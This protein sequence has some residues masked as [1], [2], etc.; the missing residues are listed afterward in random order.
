MTDAPDPDRILP[1]AALAAMPF[2]IWVW[3]PERRLVFANPAV[4]RY[5]GVD[6]AELPCG[7]PFRDAVRLLAYRGAFGPGDPEA[8]VAQHLMLD[9]SRPLRR[10][11]RRADGTCHE[12]HNIPL[13]GGGFC[14]VVIEITGYIAATEEATALVRRLETVLTNL[15]SGLALYDAERRL[16]LSNPAY[17]DLIGLPRSTVR[18]GMTQQEVLEH[19]VRRGEIADTEL[20]KITAEG[21]RLDRTNHSAWQ[22][23]RPNGQVVRCESQPMPCGGYLVEITDITAARRAEDEARRRAALLDGVLA[24]LPHGVV[25]YGPDQRVAMVNAAHQ[26][27][28]AGSEIAVG[29]HR[30]EIAWR[31]ANAGEYGPGDPEAL[32]REN[33]PALTG[34]QLVRQ[35]RVRPNGTVLDIQ[36]ATLPDGGRVQ[37]T[38]DITALHRA[39]T[40]AT[41][42]AALLQVMLDNMRHGIALF[43][44][45]R[46]LVA[47]NALAAK[48]M[49]LAPDRLWPGREID[50]IIAEQGANGEFG[51]TPV[52]E[53][54][55]N[56]GHRDRSKPL[57]Y[58]RIRPDGTVVEV[59]S[60]PTPDGGFVCTYSDITARARAEAEAREQAATLQATIDNLRHGVILYGPDRRVRVANA[61]TSTLAGHPPGAIRPGQTLEELVTGMAKDGALGEG[62]EAEAARAR[63]LGA[64]RSKS[65]R[66]IR[67]TRDG[68][69]LEIHS[70]PMPDGGFIVSQVDITPLAR[71]EAAARERATMLQSM[72]DN[73]RH[74]IALYGPD[75]RLLV[76]NPLAARLAF[77]RPEE[78]TPGRSLEEMVALQLERGFFGTGE[79]A[80]ALAE[81]ALRV[82]RSQPERKQRTMPDGRVLETASDPTPDGGFVVTWSD[83]T[84]LARAEEAAQR[85]AGFLQAMLDNI[86]H[87]I[88]LFDAEN[89]VVAANPVFRQLLD[90]PEE[91]VEPGRPYTD[92][93]D[94]LQSR[95]EYGEGEAGLAV[96][97]AIKSRDRRQTVRSVR[98][99]PN[100]TVLEIVSDPTPDGGWVLTFTDVTEDRRIRAELERAKEA[101]EAANRA[102]SR[103]LATMSHELRTPL[104]AVIGFSEAIMA[105]PDP[106]RGREYLR[107]IHEAGRHLLSLIDDILDVT[108]AE[109]TGFQVSEGEVDVLALAEGSV[110][111]MRATAAAAQ[112]TLEA[113]LPPA[114]PLVRADEL[115][116]RQVLLNLLSNA[117][118]FTPAGGVVRLAAE[119]EPAGDLVLRVSDTGIGIPP[120]EIPRAFEPFTQLDGSLSRR[121]PGSGL[122]LYLSR[123]LAEAQGAELTLESAPGAGT[124]AVLRIPKSRLLA[125]LAA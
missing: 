57:H 94:L 55:R 115:R 112:V 15:H 48:L 111:V 2:G 58:T 84:A 93:V 4:W 101:A 87:G 67:T 5:A 29:E 74:G 75:R 37:V 88:A 19:L 73:T 54:I 114:L 122:G 120:E 42:R 38:T 23:E 100:G 62:P 24:S 105:D 81:Q 46:R 72:L 11:L 44:A 99:R 102:K 125:P 71:A 36:Y 78:M 10:I 108:R 51:S 22:R 63:I 61:L 66:N 8:Q 79:E 1:A 39:R 6:P 124:M 60:D 104:N 113:E 80:L 97:R 98:T 52:A 69:V 9:R 59:I 110:R 65:W 109:T 82:D 27:I 103:F 21:R 83:I 17:E 68:R 117:V 7:T 86:R 33:V 123:A 85:R 49:G 89:R 14:S 50:D 35:Q 76:A 107:S 34:G 47:S 26:S 90:L 13:P 70:D 3:D 40:V 20:D 28:M 16:V 91:V 106:V 92:F 116:L 64:D 41:E 30:E 53:V 118:K 43:D 12:L 96:A 45:E 119:V 121:F 18:P 31:R 77:L 32:M 95:G 56:A 25:V